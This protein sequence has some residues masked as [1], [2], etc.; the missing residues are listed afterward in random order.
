MHEIESAKITKQQSTNNQKTFI[1]SIQKSENKKTQKMI[2][3]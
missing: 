2:D 3:L 1:L